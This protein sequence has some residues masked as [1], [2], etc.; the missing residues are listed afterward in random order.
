[1]KETFK[2]TSKMVFNHFL[3]ITTILLFMMGLLKLAC[4]LAGD[5]MDPLPWIFPLQVIGVSLPTAL[6]SYVYMGK[7]ELTKNQF[8]VRC[9]IHFIL[10]IAIVL[11]EGFAFE[12]YGDNITGII[13]VI[14]IFFIIYVCVWVITSIK[15]KRSSDNINKALHNI[16]QQEEDE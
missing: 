6:C 12:W 7:K 11:G 4:Y 13:P 14:I 8:L 5:N 16:K 1:M 9:T 10:L 2:Q 15:D 3:L